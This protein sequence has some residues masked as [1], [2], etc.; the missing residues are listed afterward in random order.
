MN[1]TAFQLYSQIM[2]HKLS[3]FPPQNNWGAGC[4]HSSFTLFNH[5]SLLQLVKG[6]VVATDRQDGTQFFNFTNINAS[7]S[8]GVHRFSLRDRGDKVTLHA[9]V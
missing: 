6:N 5:S 3:L 7:A 8:G 9:D 1:F 2:S 4:G